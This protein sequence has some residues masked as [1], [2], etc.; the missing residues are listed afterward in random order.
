MFAVS[1]AKED[2]PV[3]SFKAI[4]STSLLA[5][6]RKTTCVSTVVSADRWAKP[7]ICKLAYYDL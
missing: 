3:A 6:S 1:V 2:S 7:G 5:S 4:S